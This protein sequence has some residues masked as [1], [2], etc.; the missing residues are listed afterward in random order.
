[1]TAHRL[2]AALALALLLPAFA[3]AQDDEPGRI[4]ER[5]LSALRD[6]QRF[7]RLIHEDGSDRP[8]RATRGSQQRLAAELET[9][10]GD[11]RGELEQRLAVLAARIE[12]LERRPVL[13]QALEA[14]LMAGGHHPDDPRAIPAA[15][16]GARARLADSRLLAAWDVDVTTG[17]VD[18]LETAS[19]GA[20]DSPAF[21]A[22]LEQTRA[23]AAVAASWGE[24]LAELVTRLDEAEA[25]LSR[26]RAD[27][28]AQDE[29]IAALRQLF[30]EVRQ[31]VQRRITDL[32]QEIREVDDHM[33]GEARDYDAAIRRLQE[34]RQE[35]LA[36]TARTTRDEEL[37]QARYEHRVRRTEAWLSYLALELLTVTGD[38]RDV[39]LAELLALLT[40]RT[41]VHFELAEGVDGDARLDLVVA[42]RS[43]RAVADEVARRAGLAWSLSDPTTVSFRAAERIELED[44]VVLQDLDLEPSAL[45]PAAAV[46]DTLVL[47]VDAWRGD[48]TEVAST[49]D[50]LPLRLVLGGD[51]GP[52]ALQAGLAG[53]GVGGRRRIFAP[54]DQA[55]GLE[56]VDPAGWPLVFEVE[57]LGIDWAVD[58][59][60][61]AAAAI[62]RVLDSRV[63]TVNFADT[64]LDDCLQFLQDVTGL[65]FVLRVPSNGQAERVSHRSP[66]RPLRAVLDA[67]LAP[68]ELTWS[69]RHEAI[70][71]HG[72]EPLLPTVSPPVDAATGLPS[73]AYPLHQRVSV[74]FYDVPL[75]DVVSFLRDTVGG[76][77]VICPPWFGDGAQI[78]LR[79]DDL[80]LHSVLGLI[81]QQ[82][83]CT[84]ETSRGVIWL[85]SDERPDRLEAADEILDRLTGNRRVTLDVPDSTLADC[86]ALFQDVTG[87]D[88]V[89]SPEVDPEEA[90]VS[91][92]LRDVSIAPWLEAVTRQAQV[93]IVLE[94]RILWILDRNEDAP[95][96]L[97]FAADNALAERLTG[98]TSTRR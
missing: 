54:A 18:E 57:L 50:G 70:V 43:V 64:P 78:T 22:A 88:V 65:P 26:L 56:G 8:L 95:E 96:A 81:G 59:D 77:Y 68:L 63:V 29:E 87:L 73:E 23:A 67:I 71:I 31:G 11:A 97:A 79:V 27:A 20:P 74:D 13:R 21:D 61:H 30:D 14:A 37:E 32:R 10:R 85:A 60:L 24:C 4:A 34:Q 89:L 75:G 46:G 5:V 53:L 19:V 83:G 58:P 25:E 92:R 51:R 2:G 82:T 6:H 9:T 17:L 55:G 47:H 86:L 33:L 45:G 15:I 72:S 35:L 91:L 98:R 39:G 16:E 84:W 38:W 69:I 76:H 48:G 90:W 42:D 44:G 49:R 36:E 93:R 40:A 7:V 41:R 3:Q 94:R 12:L 66:E 1:M 52:R 28:A 62:A 80:R